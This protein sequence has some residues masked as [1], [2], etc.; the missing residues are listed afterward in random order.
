M[1]PEFQGLPF[2]KIPQFNPVSAMDAPYARQMLHP[3]IAHEKMPFA[4]IEQ[5]FSTFL[6]IDCP[7]LVNFYTW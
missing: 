6:R 7:F 4:K 3:T 5:K 2:L 1:N